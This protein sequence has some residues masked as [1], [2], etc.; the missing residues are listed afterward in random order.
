MYSAVLY[1]YTVCTVQYCIYT[2]CV[3]CS[4]LHVTVRR[5]SLTTILIPLHCDLCC[6]C[7]PPPVYSGWPPSS[8]PPRGLGQLQPDPAEEETVE[9]THLSAGRGTESHQIF[10]SSLTRLHRHPS[11]PPSYMTSLSPR[12]DVIMTPS[13]PH[14]IIMTSS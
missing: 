7:L 14:D 9:D 2:Q 12:H 3:Q 5:C 1:I 6:A 11:R 4:V 10:I 8:L 13:Q